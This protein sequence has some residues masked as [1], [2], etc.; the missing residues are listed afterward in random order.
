MKQ[1]TQLYSQIEYFKRT[2]EGLETC[3]LG[4]E[5]QK[6][7]DDEAINMFFNLEIFRLKPLSDFE[8]GL[9]YGDRITL[10]AYYWYDEEDEEENTIR[11]YKRANWYDSTCL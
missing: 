7:S 1:T 3:A 8:N 11:L 2:C 6:V 10:K 9:N 4:E 5:P